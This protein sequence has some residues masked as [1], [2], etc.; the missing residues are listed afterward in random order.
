MVF[1]QNT[2]WHMEHINLHLNEKASKY[3]LYAR[4]L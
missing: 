4:L 3:I 2:N 1:F